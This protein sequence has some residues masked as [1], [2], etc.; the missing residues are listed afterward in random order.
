MTVNTEHVKLCRAEVKLNHSL[1]VYNRKQG[2]LN[3]NKLMFNKKEVRITIPKESKL[4]NNKGRN[5]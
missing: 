3:T 1:N 5:Q 4:R 2:R